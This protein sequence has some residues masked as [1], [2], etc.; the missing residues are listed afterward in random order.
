MDYMLSLD[1]LAPEAT[2]AG[3]SQNALGRGIFSYLAY[4]Y[5]TGGNTVPF[6]HGRTY[7]EGIENLVPRFILP[8][9]V[10]MN[11]GNWTGQLF[12][13]V[14]S[15]DFITNVSPSYLGEF[16]MNNGI[17]GVIMGMIGLAMV[18]R[19]I[20]ESI[21][22]AKHTWLKVLFVMNVLWLEGFIGTTVLIFCKTFLMFVLLVSMLWLLDSTKR[23]TSH[24]KKSLESTN[25]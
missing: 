24:L 10:D 8:D 12:G 16:Y 18:A 23:R 3:D 6:L 25:T 15:F 11:M 9:K 17:A 13:H 21:F 14:S 4:I 19:I 1:W 2:P 5:K 20:D 22:R 7:F